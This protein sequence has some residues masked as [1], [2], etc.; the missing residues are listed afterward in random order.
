VKYQFINNLPDKWGDLTSGELGA[1][2]DVWREQAHRLRKSEIH[3]AFN[4]RLYRRWAIETGIIENLYD[5][6][7]GTTEVLVEQ[8][9]TESLIAHG[10][11]NKPVGFVVATLKAHRSSID[12]LFDFIKNNRRL[13]DSYIKELHSLL[14]SAQ[15]TTE[16]VD[17]F[18]NAV[19]LELKKG[20]WKTLENNPTRPDGEKHFYC[21]PEHV[22]SEIDNLIAWHGEHLEKQV[23]PEIEAAWLHHRFA[24]IH[25]FQDGN[26]RVARALASLVLIRG[27]L[28]PF[29]VSREDRSRYIDA[30]E[31]ADEGDLTPLVRMVERTQRSAIKQALSIA[32]DVEREREMEGLVSSI[33]KKIQDRR[34]QKYTELLEKSSEMAGRI[35]NISDEK[36]KSTSEML[37]STFAEANAGDVFHSFYS[38]SDDSNAFWFKNQIETIARNMKYYADTRTY[39]AWNRLVVANGG[40]FNVVFSIHCL[41]YEF[42]GT[43]C[44]SAFLFERT[45]EG[46][47]KK[48]SPV[49][50]IMDDVFIFTHEDQWS[51]LE[52]QYKRWLNEAVLVALAQFKEKV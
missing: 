49:V 20:V 34:H 10:S 12:F 38:S 18:G 51:L 6:D 3:K 13:T 37:N 35:Y 46:E 36:L 50:P 42:S 41:G 32:G 44:V 17:S 52:T 21:P 24:Q 23:P 5:L 16:G 25:P 45:N 9:F 33:G 29:I 14:A 19:E 11:T 39:R 1:L 26:G 27:G 47:E 30:L 15:K 48:E 43:M 28:F 22:Q 4:E 31:T 2:A 40:Q 7:R 8:G